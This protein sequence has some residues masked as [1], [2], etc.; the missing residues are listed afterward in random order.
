MSRS[1]SSK[2]EMSAKQAVA[3]PP[4][5]RMARAVVSASP[6]KAASSFFTHSPLLRRQPGKLGLIQYVAVVDG[7][8]FAVVGD[9]FGPLRRQGQ[10]HPPGPR[11]GR[12]R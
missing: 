4:A 8:G 10:G 12:S 6:E 2:R 5:S 7:D 9:H 11:P 3:S 1:A